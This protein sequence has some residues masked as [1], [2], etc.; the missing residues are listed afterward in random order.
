MG[1]WQ[2]VAMDSQSLTRARHALPFYA[3]RVVVS[4]VTR[5]QDGRPAAVFYLLKHPTPYVYAGV[6]FHLKAF[7]VYTTTCLIFDFI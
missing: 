2:A 3:L 1:V 5:L 4:G 6:C 7:A